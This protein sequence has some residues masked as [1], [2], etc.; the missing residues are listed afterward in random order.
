M[1]AAS[2]AKLRNL[3]VEANEPIEHI[4]TRAV[5]KLH[6]LY[7][8]AI[9]QL[10]LIPVSGEIVPRAVFS[11]A[12]S[13][14]GAVLLKED[15]EA[16]LVVDR[17]T[18]IILTTTETFRRIADGSCSPVEAYLDGQLHLHGNMELGRR[19]VRR[20]AAPGE[21]I[22][23][24]PLPADEAW[25]AAGAVALTCSRDFYVRQRKYLQRRGRVHFAGA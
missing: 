18:L 25:Q 7:E 5:L 1:V 8:A 21:K 20:L 11:I 23:F 4:V 17:T 10:R 22:R 13:P 2:Y 24:C 6:C 16:R 9:V 14:A 3:T 15:E 19:I 12:V